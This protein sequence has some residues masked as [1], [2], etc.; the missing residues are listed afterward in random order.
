[1]LRWVGAVGVSR[2]AVDEAA[3]EGDPGGIGGVVGVGE[4]HE[5]TCVAVAVEVG[6]VRAVAGVE[7]AGAAGSDSV[8]STAVECG[9]VLVVSSAGVV[10]PDEAAGADGAAR[11]SVTAGVDR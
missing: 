6:S 5:G 10:R 8:V 9:P 1:M 3:A 4:G 7:V 2:A 11:V